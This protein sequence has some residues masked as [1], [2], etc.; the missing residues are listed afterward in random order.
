[1]EFLY[2]LFL[3]FRYTVIIDVKALKPNLTRY[4]LNFLNVLIKN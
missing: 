4:I 3:L 2:L 1:M